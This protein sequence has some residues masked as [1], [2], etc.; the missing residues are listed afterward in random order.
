MKTIR[1]TIGNFSL[2]LT[3][4]FNFQF[5]IFIVL[6]TA[7]AIPVGVTAVAP[8]VTIKLRPHCESTM[9]PDFPRFDSETFITNGLKVGDMLD[10]DI[11]LSNPTAQP[12]QSVQSWLEYDSSILEGV[13]VR[14]SD[15]FPLVAP[16]EQAFA[17][18]PGSGQAPDSDRGKIGAS[19]VSGGM[20]DAEIVFARVTFKVLKE[21]EETVKI[22]FHDFS[23]LGQEGKT[24]VLVIEGGRTAN[25]LKT[26]PDDLRLFFGEG[27]P[28][29]SVP[30]P[31]ITQPP[32]TNPPVATPPV[33]TLP[34]T[35]PPVTQPYPTDPTFVALQPQG[36]RVMTEG[37]PPSPD[38][39]RGAGKV[40][41]IWNPVS[42]PRVVGYNIYYGTVSGRYIQR[43]TVSTETTGVT[44]RNLPVGTRYYFAVTAFN[45]Q[46][47]DSEYSYEVAVTVGDPASS[48]APFTLEAGMGGSSIDGSAIGG[49]G[50]VPGGTGMPLIA[51]VA[52]AVI[53]FGASSASSYLWKKFPRRA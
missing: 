37:D 38:G 16:G 45:A 14:I 43:R 46:G 9:C 18:R 22:G 25:I 7:A 29:G 24:K 15:S 11:I 44:I 51:L 50:K 30:T 47:Q 41:L 20:K 17:P 53:S 52:V 34:I 36:L 26:R 35:Q 39:L 19:N 40:Y 2:S 8:D 3:S 10:I 49:G 27:S 33:T 21:T 48:I 5:S 12:I 1:A 28:S 6:L 13:D 32:V 4:I 42:D 23:L 31:P